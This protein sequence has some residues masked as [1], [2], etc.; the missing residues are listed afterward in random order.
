[1]LSSSYPTLPNDTVSLEELKFLLEMTGKDESTLH[2][3][4]VLLRRILTL[5]SEKANHCM[6]PRVEVFTLP[7]DL[8]NAQAIALIRWNRYGKIPIRGETP[9]EILGILDT[10]NFLLSPQ[11]HYTKML[12]PPFL[13]PETIQVIDLLASF[14]AHQQDVAILLDEYGGTEGIV[15]LSDLL[16]KVFGKEDHIKKERCL[17]SM[18]RE[19]GGK[20]LASG[21][22]HLKDL[23]KTLEISI[24]GYSAHTIGGMLVEHFGQL[25]RVGSS[26]LLG[27]WEIHVRRTS[28]KRVL[29]VLISP[30]PRGSHG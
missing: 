28:R 12:S 4:M 21:G 6:I 14:R 17:S 10:R 18:E 26:I 5:S 11:R 25:P 19:K 8:T 7:G 13:V 27:N 2:E 9:D 22:F 23:E 24:S 16:E 30:L 15:T 3:E 20:F 29:E 1:M